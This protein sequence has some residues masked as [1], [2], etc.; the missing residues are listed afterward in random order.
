MRAGC[1]QSLYESQNNAA[2]AAQAA[3]RP[4]KILALSARFDRELARLQ[5]ADDEACKRALRECKISPYFESEFAPLPCRPAEAP[6]PSADPPV[7][8]TPPSTE[9]VPQ[10]VGHVCYSDSMF[11]MFLLR[12]QKY[13]LLFFSILC[14]HVLFVY[15]VQMISR[16]FHGEFGL[17]N[18]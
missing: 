3:A 8:D 9:D 2:L 18:F 1:V 10:A 14:V 4:S 15:F 5:L 17:I 6:A 13:Q 11:Y 16:F 7:E 12:F